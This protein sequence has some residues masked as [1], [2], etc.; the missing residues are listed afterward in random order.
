MRAGRTLPAGLSFPAELKEELSK[1]KA[2]ANKIRADSDVLL[3]IGIGG[4]YLG[5]KAVTD[6]LL[7]QYTERRPELVFAGNG[8]SGLRAGNI[9]SYLQ[10]K[11]FSINVISKS[12]TTTE[13][14]VAFRVFGASGE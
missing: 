2:A 14:A 7:P 9:L 4:S 12:G 8:L 1:I 10:D 5:A 6:M 13:P 11:D 3:V